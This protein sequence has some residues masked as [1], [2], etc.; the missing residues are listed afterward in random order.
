MKVPRIRGRSPFRPQTYEEVE[1][2]AEIQRTEPVAPT[3]A[4]IKRRERQILGPDWGK[5]R[6]KYQG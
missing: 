6:R 4:D 3:R 5:P 2:V 1:Y